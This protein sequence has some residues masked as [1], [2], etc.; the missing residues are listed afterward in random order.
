MN[1]EPSSTVIVN[2][3]TKEVEDEFQHTPTQRV[4]LFGHERRTVAV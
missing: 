4:M 2:F 3:A 1:K